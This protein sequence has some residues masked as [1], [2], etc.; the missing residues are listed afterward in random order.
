MITCQ[1]HVVLDRFP[2]VH[3][4]VRIVHDR[5]HL[6][7]DLFPVALDPLRG[8]LGLFHSILDRFPTVHGLLPA[9]PDRVTYRT[10]PR[11]QR[12]RRGTS[13]TRPRPYGTRWVHQSYLASSR[14]YLMRYKSY[15]TPSATYT[16]GLHAIPDPFPMVQDGCTYA[17]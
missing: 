7:H 3:D 13:H 2:I 15:P 9:I 6:L 1:F 12:T 11:P 14:W 4:R 17:T 8:I 5:L 16:T 10:R